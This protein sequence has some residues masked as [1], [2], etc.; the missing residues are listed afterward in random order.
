[1]A[2]LQIGASA[3]RH[4]AGFL[5]F[6]PLGANSERLLRRVLGFPA[7]VAPCLQAGIL[8]STRSAIGLSPRKFGPYPRMP[9]Q[10]FHQLEPT[11]K[12]TRSHQCYHPNMIPNHSVPADILLPH[13]TYRDVDAAVAWLSRVFGFKEHYRYGSNPTSGAQMYL[14]KAYIMVNRPKDRTASPA[15]LGSATQ[16]LTVFVEGIEAHFA[17]AKSAGAQ[18]VEEL[19]ETEYGEFQY[20]SLDLDGHHWLFS[21]HAKDVPPEAWGAKVTS[22]PK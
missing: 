19:H 8:G 12:T 1:M 16:S 20:A 18:I 2:E 15:Q 6:S 13:I 17:N 22:P 7:V 21:R 5:D 4:R 11:R 14:G 10:E 9:K 3:P